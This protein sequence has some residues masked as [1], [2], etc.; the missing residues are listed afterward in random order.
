V[1]SGCKFFKSSMCTTFNYTLYKC[2]LQCTYISNNHVPPILLPT[3]KQKS[4]INLKIL[5]FLFFFCLFFF[6]IF[7]YFV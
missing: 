3:I 4:D 6:I 1:Y 7:F 5:I 2:H